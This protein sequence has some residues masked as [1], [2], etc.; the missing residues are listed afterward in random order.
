MAIRLNFALSEQK[1]HQN[2][3]KKQNQNSLEE[4]QPT[5]YFLLN[6][7]TA[8]AI[9]KIKKPQFMLM[10]PAAFEFRTFSFA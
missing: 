6:G 10:L 7:L 1:I 5:I 8:S 4:N 2:I 3:S 9:M